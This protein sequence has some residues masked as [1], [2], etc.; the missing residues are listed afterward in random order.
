MPVLS[1]IEQCADLTMRIRA[2]CQFK[3]GRYADIR[4]TDVCGKRQ[5]YD[6]E[7]SREAFEKYLRYVYEVCNTASV[8]KE[9]KAKE[10]KDVQPGDILV[11]PS[12]QKGRYGHAILVADVARNKAGK[13]AILCVEGNNPAREA[14]IV[15]NPNL[16]RNLWFALDDNDEV[17]HISVFHFNKEELRH[18]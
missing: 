14:H 10:L 4:F 13:I 18:Y 12:R 15:R 16:F 2:E 9:T 5:A 11:Y 6:G 3:E 8:Y 7:A 17:I 1:N